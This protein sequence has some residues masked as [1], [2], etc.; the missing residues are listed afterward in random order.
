[1]FGGLGEL[2]EVELSWS[3]ISTL[4]VTMFLP[5]RNL[6]KVH[7]DFNPIAFTGNLQYLCPRDTSKLQN[8]S[9]KFFVL[10]KM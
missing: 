3:R 8:L 9:I 2:R 10:I 4:P 1:M 6:E 5:N 7:L